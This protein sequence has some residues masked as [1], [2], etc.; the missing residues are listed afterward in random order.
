M[1]TLKIRFSSKEESVLDSIASYYRDNGCHQLSKRVTYDG[2]YYALDV[3]CNYFSKWHY[4]DLL[5]RTEGKEFFFGVLS[6]N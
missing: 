2:E 6:S 5:K 4:L 3:W 1:A